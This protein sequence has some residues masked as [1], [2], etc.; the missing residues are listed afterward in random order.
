M[1]PTKADLAAAEA[2]IARI[3]VLME[4]VRQLGGSHP[5]FGSVTYLRIERLEPAEE[6]LAA[7]REAVAEPA[8]ESHRRA[9]RAYE[10]RHPERRARSIQFLTAKA[11]RMKP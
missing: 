3:R 8:R 9:R 1:T 4:R 7:L 5:D 10:L 11:G 6:R 2:E